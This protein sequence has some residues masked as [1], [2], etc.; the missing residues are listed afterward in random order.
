LARAGAR[1]NA[2]IACKGVDALVA[3]WPGIE[4]WV[5]FRRTKSRKMKQWIRSEAVHLATRSSSP[6][7]IGGAAHGLDAVFQANH[8]PPPITEHFLDL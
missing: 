1:A 3:A 4:R 7:S 8:D 5:C 2:R 6:R